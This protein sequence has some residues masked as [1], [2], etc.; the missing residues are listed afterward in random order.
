MRVET[1][2]HQQQRKQA[3]YFKV[4]LTLH[5]CIHTRKVYAQVL[6][7]KKQIEEYK[8]RLLIEYYYIFIMIII[9]LCTLFIFFFFAFAY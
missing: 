9:F 7:Y 3:N 8:A 4:K 6:N 5:L 2:R 1:I